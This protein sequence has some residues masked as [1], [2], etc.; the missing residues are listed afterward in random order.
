[1]QYSLTKIIQMKKHENLLTSEDNR[2]EA[3]ISGQRH[4]KSHILITK[5]S[6]IKKV[7]QIILHYTR[8]RQKNTT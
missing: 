3:V 5:P 2:V 6:T 1:M 4:Y 8:K 7:R